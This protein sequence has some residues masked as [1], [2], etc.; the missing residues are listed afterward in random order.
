[1]GAYVRDLER[2]I[3]RNFNPPAG[4]SSKLAMFRLV[5]ARSGQLL[6]CSLVR[7]SGSDI[8][9][10]SARSAIES[11]SPFRTLPSGFRE[12]QASIDFKLD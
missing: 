6:S 8:F 5:I 12:S 3:R 1:M 10:A 7:S 9:D 2:R 11:S 4:N